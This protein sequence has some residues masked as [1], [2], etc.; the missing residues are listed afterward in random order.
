VRDELSDRFALP[1]PFLAGH[2]GPKAGPSAV[3]RPRL[4]TLQPV[5]LHTDGCCE[6]RGNEPGA[7]V[8]AGSTRGPKAHARGASRACAAAPGPARTPR[9]SRRVRRPVGA[10]AGVP[11]EGGAGLLAAVAGSARAK[12]LVAGLAE[13][14]AGAGCPASGPGRWLGWG[15]RFAESA[16]SGFRPA[17]STRIRAGWGP[18]FTP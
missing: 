11:P 15:P 16:C 12:A 1:A 13:V 2:R 5:S 4:T 14:S 8:R 3:T 10:D 17:C 7:V 18:N 9:S 6:R